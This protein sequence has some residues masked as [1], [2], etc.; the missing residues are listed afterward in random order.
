MKENGWMNIPESVECDCQQTV[1]PLFGGLHSARASSQ[2]ASLGLA[3]V[4]E[5]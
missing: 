1:A 3:H 2:K 5:S 4:Q